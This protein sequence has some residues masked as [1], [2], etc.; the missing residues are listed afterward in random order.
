M[1][2]DHGIGG[3]K[4][5]VAF[6]VAA[7]NIHRTGDILWKLEQLREQIKKKYSGRSPPCK[8]AA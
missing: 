5:Y 7:R 4:R 3:F 8:L 6:A 1:R 2:Q